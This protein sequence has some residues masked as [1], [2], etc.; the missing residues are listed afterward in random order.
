[1]RLWRSAVILLVV[2]SLI[3]I[4]GSG[5]VDAFSASFVPAKVTASDRNGSPASVRGYPIVMAEGSDGAIWYG[6]AAAYGVEY[7]DRVDRITPDGKFA[8]FLFSGELSDRWP[9]SFA[10]GAKGTEWFLAYS[11]STSIPMLVNIAPTGKMSIVHLDIPEGTEVRGL[12]TGHDGYLWTT[13]TRTQHHKRSSA[14]LRISAGG[15]I[16]WFSKG[17]RADADPE[18]IVAGPHG[19]MWFA[20]AAGSIGRVGTNGLI[21]EF[22]IGRPMSRLAESPSIELTRPIV[23]GGDGNLWFIAARHTIGRMSP[24]GKVRFFMPRA[25]R[26][27]GINTEWG[28]L[29]GLASGPTGGIWFTRETGEVARIS[30]T[31]RVEAVTNRLLHAYGIAFDNRG[32]AWVGEGPQFRGGEEDSW[33]ARV[34]RI[35]TAARVT[36]YPAAPKCRIPS[37][38]GMDRSFAAEKATGDST[39]G[40]ENRLSVNATIRRGGRGPYMVVAQSPRAGV[41]RE[42]YVAI[43]VTLARVRPTPTAGCSA[44]KFYPRILTSPWLSVWKV[45]TGSSEEDAIETYYACKRPNGVTHLIARTE[46]MNPSSDWISSFLSAGP[47]VAYIEDTGDQYYADSFTLAVVDGTSGRQ[48][49]RNKFAYDGENE[50]LNCVYFGVNAL[51]DAVWLIEEIHWNEKENKRSESDATDVLYEHDA[52]GTRVIGTDLR[53][54]KVTLKGQVVTWEAAGQHLAYRLSSVR[55]FKDESRARRAKLT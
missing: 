13:A 34:G 12:A 8:D 20:D 35:S 52:K 42:G 4:L 19:A 6:G 2:I 26:E 36:Q 29:V 39:P 24:S 50:T 9:E 25:V 55:P 38:T 3:S 40:C 15:G 45:V 49:F 23:I 43:N 54:S 5:G 21:K 32:D 17:L 46:S 47:V 31:G 53:I 41:K 37:L 48:I 44:P 7:V 16:T 51:G 10:P 28:G 27:R 14:I 1:M 33:H 11:V 30:A 22:P 18:N